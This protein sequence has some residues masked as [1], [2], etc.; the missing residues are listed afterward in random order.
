MLKITNYLFSA[1]AMST[2][3]TSTAIAG[4]SGKTVS[5][6]V[7]AQQRAALAKNT[8]GAGFGPQAPRDIDNLDGSNNRAFGS[9]PSYTS[10]NLCNIH[11]HENAEHK[12]GQFTKYAGNGNGKG[13]D[14]G[15]EYDGELTE[16]ELAPLDTKIG[17]GKY[18]DLVP[19]DTIEVHYV[20]TTAKV[21][22]GP[23]LSSCLSESIKNPQLRVEAQVFILVNDDSAADFVELAKHDKVNGVFQAIN[24]P[25]TTGAPVQ[26]EGSTTGPSYNEAGSPFQVSWSVRPKVTKVNIKTVD[27]W[28]K[29]NIYEETAAHGVRNLV[30]NSA[31]LS[32]ID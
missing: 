16:A 5:D 28:L 8:D 25:K 6:E 20:H 7:V 19:G 32:R 31:L 30:R 24:I 26:Y 21:K 2:L 3:I 10:M 9:A 22:P 18:G 15:F 13:A 1:V 12:G 17:D 11:F 23:T 14:T 29:D 27:T 4:S